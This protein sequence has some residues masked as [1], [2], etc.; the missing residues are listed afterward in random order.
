MPKRYNLPPLRGSNITVPYR[1]GTIFRQKLADQR[2]I[3]LVMW[4]TGVDPDTGKV[5]VRRYVVSG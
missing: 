5:T 1:P 3:D 4:V 2:Q